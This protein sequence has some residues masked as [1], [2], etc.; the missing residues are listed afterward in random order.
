[1][2][3][4]G[5]CWKGYTHDCH[6]RCF[7]LCLMKLHVLRVLELLGTEKLPIVCCSKCQLRTTKVHLAK[8]TLVLKFSIRRWFKL[9][10]LCTCECECAVVW[11]QL[12]PFIYFFYCSKNLSTVLSWWYTINFLVVPKAR[13]KCHAWLGEPG[14]MSSFLHAILLRMT[15]CPTTYNTIAVKPATF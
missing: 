2:T 14:M 15:H 8:M 11:V 10:T 1:M 7:N 4:S 9:R 12:L 5:T 6:C 3:E 13:Q